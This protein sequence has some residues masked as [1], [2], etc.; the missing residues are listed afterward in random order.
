MS[1]CLV[2]MVSSCQEPNRQVSE[3]SLRG[4]H[5]LSAEVSF[6]GTSHICRVSE[7]GFIWQKPTV[8]DC[9]SQIFTKD[10]YGD[11]RF[12][13]SQT[14]AAAIRKQIWE[15]DLAICHWSSHWATLP[16]L[17]IRRSQQSCVVPDSQCLGAA[18]SP[19]LWIFWFMSTLICLSCSDV[20][21]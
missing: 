8:F 5:P 7:I 16:T 17:W 15:F 3:W 21:I 12:K 10:I 14:A 2:Q 9:R 19:T 18:T 4:T 6:K 13:G 1:C 11:C 20:I